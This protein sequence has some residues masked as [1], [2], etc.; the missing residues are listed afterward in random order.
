M[1]VKLSRAENHSEGLQIQIRRLPTQWGQGI[2]N[3]GFCWSS[4]WGCKITFPLCI[5]SKVKISVPNFLNKKKLWP[6][7]FLSDIFWTFLWP[8]FEHYKSHRGPLP[9]NPLLWALI[10]L[11]PLLVVLLGSFFRSQV[12]F[13]TSDMTRLETFRPCIIVCR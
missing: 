6:F 8:S 13:C 10:A 1:R 9:V 7:L 3:P 2:G 12:S 11:F 5:W 4:G